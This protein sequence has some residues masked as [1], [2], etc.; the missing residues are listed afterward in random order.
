MSDLTC[1]GIS[2][3][4]GA[5]LNIRRHLWPSIELVVS[6]GGRCLLMKKQNG[7]DGGGGG[8]VCWNLEIVAIHGQRWTRVL[9]AA[10]YRILEKEIDELQ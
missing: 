4:L 3:S 6:E 7:T 1:A 5:C 8:R 2:F 10:F 9:K